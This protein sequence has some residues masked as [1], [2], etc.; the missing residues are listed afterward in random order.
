MEWMSPIDS[1]F[2]HIENSTTPMHIGGVSIFEGP[3]PPFED[4]RAMVAGKLSLVPR[5]RQKVR[6]VPLAIGSPAWIDDPH[7]SLDYHIRHTAIPAP[8]SEAQLA[9]V[10]GC[11]FSPP[12]RPQ[13]GA[14]QGGATAPDGRSRL[15]TAPRQEQAPMG[16]VD[17]RGPDGG[18]LGAAVQGP[19]LHG[20]R[21]RGDRSDVPHVLRHDRL[22]S[23]ARMVGDAGA[24]G[25]RGSA[26][27][28]RATR[29]PGRATGLAPGRGERAAADAALDRRDRARGGGRRCQPAPGGSVVADWPDRPSPAMELGRRAPD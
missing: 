19:S 14:G 10:A 27:H 8:G 3:P 5:Y 25:S 22:R 16:A 28:H 6:F 24:I 11:G 7:F 23:G 21:R 9:Q 29:E 26:P 12:P 17:R 15:L 1:A 4:L 2:L 18:T 13:P 20:R